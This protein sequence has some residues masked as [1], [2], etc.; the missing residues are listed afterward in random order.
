MG[1]YIDERHSCQHML[2]LGCHH[3]SCR[4]TWCCHGNVLTAGT[5]SFAFKA[6]HFC[7]FAV[8][9]SRTS[10]RT[11]KADLL[12]DPSLEYVQVEELVLGTCVPELHG[13]QTGVGSILDVLAKKILCRGTVK[14]EL[15]STVVRL[16]T[17]WHS[18]T[19]GYEVFLSM[20]IGNRNEW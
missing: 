7:P 10:W 18:S 11:W 3:S 20:M 13:A 5:C 12:V 1:K 6:Q 15:S 16:I 8:A 19:Y 4:I 2:L 17:S 9:S 14:N